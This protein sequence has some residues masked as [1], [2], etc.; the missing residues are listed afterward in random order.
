MPPRLQ[1][2]FLRLLK[3]DFTLQFVPGKSLLLADMLSRAPVGQPRKDDAEQDVEVHAV[4][5][6]R[7]TCTATVIEKLSAMFA[8]Y[9]IPVEVCT[10]NGPQFASREFT[11]FSKRYD[12]THTTSSPRFPRSNGLAEKGVQVVKRILKKT[13]EGSD[14]FWLGLLSYRS[15]P[16]EDGNSPG[17]L[18]QG[19]RLRTPLPDF[20]EQPRITVRKHQQQEQPRR[21]LVPLGEGEVVRIR[22]GTWAR[23]AKVIRAVQPR[24]YRVVT[25]DGKVLRRNRQH[26][27]KTT[28]PFVPDMSD[29]DD[30]D[31]EAGDDRIPTQP[32]Y[33]T[34]GSTVGVPLPVSA[35]VRRSTRPRRPPQRLTYD[36][37]FNQC[38]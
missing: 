4:E 38:S 30:S 20:S 1:R 16:L 12:F 15:S 29:D 10:D 7:D 32:H 28:E 6:L 27:L 18:L 24:S 22:D 19:R 36:E 5:L 31:D 26:L 17:E 3:Y 14:D 37:H 9:G 25:E 8:R 33:N 35:P 23:K 21:S 13:T 2:F 11:L 34:A